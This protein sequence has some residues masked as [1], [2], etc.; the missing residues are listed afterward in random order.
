MGYIEETGAAQHYRDARILPIYEGTTGIQANDLIGRK[1]ARDKGEAARALLA[2]MR[3]TA[4]DITDPALA[5]AFREGIDA[6]AGAVDWTL[7]ATPR[8][9][10]AGGV[11]LLKLFGTVAGGWQMMRAHRAAAAGGAVADDGFR[12]AKLASARFYADHILPQAAA[13]AHAVRHGAAS[14]LALDEALFGA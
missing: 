13:L 4:A 10:A 6:L 2:E 12:Q 7:A 9:A 3:A 1:L 8:E 11:P 5:G 14:T